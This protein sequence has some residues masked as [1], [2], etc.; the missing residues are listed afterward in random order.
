MIDMLSDLFS[1]KTIKIRQPPGSLIYI[2]DKPEVQTKITI[3]D[4][5]AEECFIQEDARLEDCLK[6]LDKKIRWINVDGLNNIQYIEE[7][8]KFFNLNPLLLEDIINTQQRSKVEEYNEKCIFC[9]I[10]MLHYNDKIPKVFSEQVS[11]ILMPD[12]LITFQ[13]IQ[14]DVFDSIRERIKTAKG[15][16]RK[17]GA[18]YLAYGLLDA[19]IDDYFIVLDKIDNHLEE[20]EEQILKNDDKKN[21]DNIY[22]F[23]REIL[24]LYKSIWPL[25]EIINFLQK[26]ETGLMTENT[27][28][29]LRD[30]QDHVVQIIETIETYREI[31][32]VMVDVHINNMSYKLNDVMKLLTIFSVIFLPLMLITGIYGMNFVNIP[33]LKFA[34]GYYAVLVIMGIISLVMLIF[35]KRKKWI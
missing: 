26:I 8:G 30:L 25:R 7:I 27:K 34:W 13:E 10:K 9:I 29:Y 20:L 14:G 19:I 6:T 11:L 35:F 2:G 23:R 22:Y 18:D 31:L 24:T 32:S 4:Y 17:N 33:E 16:I 21:I 28:V 15:K 1:K 3:I 5:N 12:T